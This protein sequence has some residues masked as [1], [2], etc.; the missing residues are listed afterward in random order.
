METTCQGAVDIGS[1]KCLNRTMQYGNY[2]IIKYINKKNDSLNRTMQYG[3][4]STS[5][6]IAQ[7]FQS[8]NRTMQ[9]GN[10]MSGW[11][12]RCVGANV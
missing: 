12:F 8:L 4:F 5:E 6:C 11:K 9:Y 7:L 2:I 3:N 1:S 10:S